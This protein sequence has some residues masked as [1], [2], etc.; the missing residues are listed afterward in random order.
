MVGKTKT[1]TKAQRRRFASLQTRGCVAC[2]LDGRLREPP[3]IHH[4]VEGGRRLGHDYTIP[5]CPWHHR[6]LPPGGLSIHDARDILGPSLALAKRAFVERYGDERHLL[7]VA[8]LMIDR[9]EGAA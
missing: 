6:G 2:A 5:L 8:N 3:D 7:T 9:M 4:L 1:P